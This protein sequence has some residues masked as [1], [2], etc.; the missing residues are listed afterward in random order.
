MQKKQITRIGVYGV[1]IHN[2]SML[3]VVQQ[4]GPFTGKFEF[5][6]GGIEFGESPEETLRR[7]FI[8]E[9][10]MTFTSMEISANI[11]ATTDVPAADGRDPYVFHQIGLIYIVHGIKP[12]ENAL[13]GELPHL[14]VD[15][16][17]LPASTCSA[18]LAKYLAI[19][20]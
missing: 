18:L 9:V 2:N 7:E 15:L 19:A 17:A 6:G 12:L 11:T 13:Q 16:H 5:P 4:Q 1:A 8:E 20:K 3:A 10:G 14:W